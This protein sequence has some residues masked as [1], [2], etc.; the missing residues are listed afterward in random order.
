[1]HVLPT[2][3]FVFTR[4]AFRTIRGRLPVLFHSTLERHGF[5][6]RDVTLYVY[7]KS[8]IEET[9]GDPLS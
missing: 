8:R 7:G 5:E 2:V 1:M 3:F 6:H 9:S 4:S